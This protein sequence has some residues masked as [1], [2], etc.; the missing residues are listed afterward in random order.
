MKTI[1]TYKH[2]SNEER[3]VIEKLRNKNYGIRYIAKVLDRSVCTISMEIKRNSRNNIY[4][5]NIAKQ[6]K[7]Y[8]RSNSKVDCLKVAMSSFI[9]EKVFELI[10]LKH[11]PREISGYLKREH[12]II[13]SAKAIYRFMYSR[14][15]ETKL[16]Y[17]W[18][19]KKTGPK[20][21]K[22]TKLNDGRVYIEDRPKE[23]TVFDWEMDF[24]VSKKSSFVVLVLVNRLTRFSIVQILPNRK[25]TT[26]S[27]ALSTLSKYYVMKTITTDND[28]AF[29]KWKQLEDI[30]HGKI[31]FCHPYHSWE[32]GLV[33]NT[34]RWIRCFVPKK[35][36]IALVS[37]KDLKEIDSFINHKYR[38]VTGFVS[39]YSLQ[40]EV[41]KCST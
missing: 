30:I 23:I 4:T 18:N 33:E 8:R 21:T 12:N 19:K 3:V 34:N 15:L 20:Y 32:K 37:I 41:L 7:S 22:N 13:C 11:S 9:Q 35:K 29:N 10:E 39:P 36:D 17:G 5:H 27:G 38:A 6:K 1:R 2:L 28:I 31:Y 24:I 26:I 40:L 16:F 25:H 14:S